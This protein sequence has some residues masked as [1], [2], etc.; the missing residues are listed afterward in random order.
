MP[1]PSGRP[2]I[3]HETPGPVLAILSICSA[4]ASAVVAGSTIAYQV[5][6][7]GPGRGSRLDLGW[8]ILLSFALVQLLQI[9]HLIRD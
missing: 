7:K 4:G 1:L 2:D 3:S 9:N 8:N 5:K 6:L